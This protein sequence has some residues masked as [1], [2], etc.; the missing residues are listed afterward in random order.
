MEKAEDT[1][2]G[3]GHEKNRK[4]K[5]GSERLILTSRKRKSEKHFK[6]LRKLSDRKTKQPEKNDDKIPVVGGNRLCPLRCTVMYLV[7]WSRRRSV[8]V[9]T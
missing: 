2:G 3:L 9:V 6:K 5:E 8:T 7:M 4:E 1:A